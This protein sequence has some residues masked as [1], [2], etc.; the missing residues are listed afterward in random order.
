MNQMAKGTLYLMI[1]NVTFLIS[2]Y[3][4]HFGLGRYLGPELYGTFGVILSL[5]TINRIF[6]Q[7]GT[8]QA[9]SKFIAENKDMANTIKNEALK[10]QTIISLAIFVIYFSSA[11]LISNL[12]NDPDLAGYIRL[13]AFIIP[14]S[15]IS[16][17]Y[18]ASLN[19]I[20]AFGK[21]TKSL[22]VYSVT[23]V[24]AVLA[25]VLLG[26]AISGAIVGYMIAS[27]AALIVA[28]HYCKF[29]NNKSHFEARKIVG[30]AIPIILFS[31]ASTLLMN[32]DLLFVKA[33]VEESAEIGFYTSATTLARVP[34]FIFSALSLTLLPSISKSVADKDNEQTKSYISSSLR[35][36]LLL[37]MPIAFI[38]SATSGNF[39]SLA[40]TSEYL[41]AAHS[42][43]IL[44]FGF[45]F[46]SVFAVLTTIIIGGGKPKVSMTIA[47]MLIPLDVILNLTLIPAYGL[48]GAA[49]ATTITAFVGVV[50]A[51]IYVVKRFRA[52][53]NPISFGKMCIASLAVYFISIVYPISGILLAAEYAFLFF[54]YFGLLWVLRE[55]K[56]EDIDMIKGVMTKS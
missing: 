51:S 50:I 9:V 17:T 5:L 39:I 42:L 41:P 56:K 48:E 49:L 7:T 26:F 28:K 45:I 43:S 36:L 47:L 10:I 8:S 32:I 37:V 54:V 24:F 3:A 52:L 38:V 55:I 44:I 40:Y 11:D 29:K 53:A 4:I 21:Q 14:I 19:G 31:A 1:A 23:K 13:S 25:L 6:I 16:N 22:I 35:Y 15:A 30:F 2:G 46:F 20:R 27:I 33:M 34:Y 18:S 12:L